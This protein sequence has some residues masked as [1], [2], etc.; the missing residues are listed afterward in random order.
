MGNRV[1]LSLIIPVYNA[2]KYLDDCFESIKKQ[3]FE[4]YEVIIINDGSKDDSGKI[5]D[6]YASNDSRVKVF[7]VENGGPSR[8]RNI[9]FEK[10]AGQ[11]IYC[12]DNDD[13][14]SD[15]MYFQK[16]Y[17]SLNETPV[18]ILLTGASYFKETKKCKE[19]DYKDLPQISV[20]KPYDIVEWL[21]KNKK[22]ETSCW[23]KIIN[24][25]FLVNNKFYFDE[26][27][28]VED[29]DWNLRFLQKVKTFNVL[30]CSSYTHVFR[31]G[32]ITSSKG[33][34]AYKSCLDQITAINRWTSYF[35]GYTG[36]EK[37][38]M[39]ALSF[40]NYQFFITLG[41]ASTLTDVYRKDIYVKL[42]EV[43]NVTKYSIEKKVRIL[44]FLYKS[45]GFSVTAFLMEKYYMHMR[46]AAK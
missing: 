6:V 7:H 25:E 27:L 32:S 43:D 37:L 15:S 13:C 3:S 35:E 23:T 20:D 1:F 33:E 30:R 18:D 8:A 36:N 2:E 38:R 45:A 17:E 39:A 24:R 26:D 28:L 41:R 10:A 31:A 4:D 22:Y 40:L 34:R 5:C 16:I 14:F 19:V 44:S 42:K 46:T 21:V 12:I 9:G 11:Y 29:L